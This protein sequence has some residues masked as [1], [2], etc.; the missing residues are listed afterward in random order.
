[1]ADE[2]PIRGAVVLT[3]SD[4]TIAPVGRRF[5]VNCTVAGNVPVRL[6]DG[7]VHVIT[8]PVGYSAFEYA[9]IGV[10]TTSNTAT[11]VYSNLY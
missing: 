3:P 6:R 9:V 11:A 5:A 2:S 10:N 7:S 4:T 8:V 1:M